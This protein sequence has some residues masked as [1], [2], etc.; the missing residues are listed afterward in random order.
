MDPATPAKGGEVNGTLTGTALGSGIDGVIHPGRSGLIDLSGAAW[1][2]ADMADEAEQE[3]VE[4]APG[5]KKL[6]GKFIVLF[7]AAPV[8]I[9]I[10]LGV[11]IMLLLGGGGEKHTADGGKYAEDHGSGHHDGHGAAYPGKDAGHDGGYPADGY[12]GT[13][14]AAPPPVKREIPPLNPQEAIFFDLPEVIVNL[15]SSGRSPTYLKL[16]V[17]LELHKDADTESL[18]QNLPRVMDR[19][20][21]YLREMRVQDMTGSAGLFRLKQELLRRVNTATYPVH[22]YDVLFKEMLIQ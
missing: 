9:L 10:L 20:Q 4:E 6:P 11:I 1:G 19:F 5:K 21:A 7:I 17:A 18:G 8:I 3:Q 12:G 13:S 16:T 14:A 15:N 2:R 22:V